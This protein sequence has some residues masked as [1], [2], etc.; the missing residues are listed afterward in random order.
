MSRPSRSGSGALPAYRIL[1]LTSG[2]PL[3]PTLAAALRRR[4]PVVEVVEVA[5]A[6]DAVAREAYACVVLHTD[7]AVAVEL[8]RLHR[9]RDE[10]R[11]TVIVYAGSPLPLDQVELLLTTGVDDVLELPATDEAVALRMAIVERRLVQRL[12][13]ARL[14]SDLR[15]SGTTLRGVFDGALDAMVLLDGDLVIVDANPAAAELFGVA[16]PQLVGTTVERR[17]EGMSAERDSGSFESAL[18]DAWG[19]LLREGT[20]RGAYRV[21]RADGSRRDVEYAARASI[22]PN[23][24]LVVLRDVTERLQLRDQIV[25]GDRLAAIGTMSAAL[26]HEI[27]SPLTCVIACLEHLASSRVGPDADTAVADASEAA[28]RIAE[29]SRDLRIFARADTPS[30]RSSV[31]LAATI[32][33]AVRLARYQV[34]PKADVVV[35]CDGLP[36]VRGN[37][38]TL[39]QVF[40]NLLINAAQ[41]MTVG[42]RRHRIVVRGRREGDF[43]VVDVA[44]DGPGIDAAHLPRVFDPFFTTKPAGVGTGLGLW[45]VRNVVTSAG[46]EVTIDSVPGGG[47][48]VSVRLPVA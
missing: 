28:R 32:A 17:I 25:A 14:S 45:L 21:I 40:L 48:T 1:L 19:R 43:V 10:A 24:H 26:A 35:E 42:P 23:R 4:A 11:E 46:G 33:S 9:A 5:A 37:E 15:A 47:T 16:L 6:A 30:F 39:G 8:A 13:R 34:K 7:P 31:D 36:A 18:V 27:N 20:Q 22:A 3:L 44:D 41:A 12:R 38:A 2:G 29:I